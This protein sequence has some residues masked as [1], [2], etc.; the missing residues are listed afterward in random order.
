[1]RERFSRYR[2]TYA[3]VNE[4]SIST[5]FGVTEEDARKNIYTVP[6]KL[7]SMCMCFARMDALFAR[8]SNI[9][10]LSRYDSTQEELPES[11]TAPRFRRRLVGKKEEEEEE[12]EDDGCEAASFLEDYEYGEAIDNHVQNNDAVD[13]TFNKPFDSNFDSDHDNDLYNNLSNTD[14]NNREYL[15]WRTGVDGGNETR[16]FFSS[17][18]HTAKVNAIEA[19]RL[20]MEGKKLDMEEAREAKRQNMEEAREASKLGLEK[21]KEASR[22]ELEKAK[23]ALESERLRK[24]IE[25]KERIQLMQPVQ[26]GVEIGLSFDQIQAL[27]KICTPQPQH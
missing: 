13:N 24:E 15:D 17:F 5:G 2:K 14:T 1:M 6:H 8:R 10:S 20:E 23:L 19:R 7:E 16:S 26:A 4:S 18:R 27:I 25:S 12:E 3:T 11:S 21:A 22:L 9:T